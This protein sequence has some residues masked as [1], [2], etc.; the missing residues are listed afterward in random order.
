MKNKRIIDS[1][2]QIESDLVTEDKML[3]TILENRKGILKKTRVS[4]KTFVT[5]IVCLAIFLSGT[6]VVFAMM[7][8][9]G[10]LHLIKGNPQSDNNTDIVFEVNTDEMKV[11]MDEITGDVKEAGPIIKK[12]IKTYD[13]LSSQ[14]PEI[15]TRNFKS[16]K[17]AIE[18]IGYENLNLPVI[19]G[20]NERIEVSTLGEADGN[21]TFIDLTVNYET[22]STV[23]MFEVARIYTEFYQ[24]DTYLKITSFSDD[25]EGVNYTS[26]KI[27]KNGREFD[28]VNSS[29]Y[30]NGWLDQSVFW[31][32]NKVTYFLSIRYQNK[33]QAEAD[34]IMNEWMNGF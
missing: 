15:Y 25:F 11:E 14:A 3:R 34:K 20:R 27:I 10:M 16:V 21:I 31:Q 23:S 12:Q 30:E 26:R 17:K 2:N 8:S 29:P 7:T 32:E 4:R 33:D 5:A 24:N 18:Y 6:M 28:V 1:W 13:P 9:G 22:D 19:N